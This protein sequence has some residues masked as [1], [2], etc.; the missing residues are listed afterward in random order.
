MV[1]NYVILGLI[2]FAG[3]FMVLAALLNAQFIFGSEKKNQ[4][5]M[6]VEQRKQKI[7]RGF[8]GMLGLFVHWVGDFF[9]LEFLGN[10]KRGT[11][12]V[13]GIIILILGIVAIFTGF[14]NEEI[15]FE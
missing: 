9:H 8:S 13:L 14:L 4:A 15:K 12:F 10:R 7:G 11:Y 3:I 6:Q 5:E 2:F 1:L